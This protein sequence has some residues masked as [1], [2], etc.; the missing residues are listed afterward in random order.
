MKER[1]IYKEKIHSSDKRLSRHIHHDSKS[2]EFTF[3]TSGLQIIDIEHKRLIPVLDQGQVGSCTG[4]AG[5]GAINTTP[6]APP[7]NPVFSA[8]ENGALKLYSAA[9]SMDGDGPY[10]PNDNGSSG[11]SIAKVLTKAGVISGYQHTFTLNDALK[12]LS[13]YPVIVGINWYNDMFNPD[14]DGRVHITGS[15]A[16]GHEVEA[17]KVDV[18][19][20][21]IWF[22][23]SWG[24][25]WGVNGTFYITWADFHTLLGEQGDVTVLIP[26]TVTPPTPVPPA[27]TN[28]VV[29]T[30]ETDNGIETLGSIVATR[31]DGQKLTEFTLE[32]PW[33]NNA[34]NIS[35]IPKGTY[36]CSIKPFHSTTQ[37]EVL[38]VP[39]RS[40]IYLHTGNY[41]HDSMGCI[42]LG[43]GQ[44]DI[45]H[46]G[47]T[48]VTNST[49]AVSALKA[50]FSS[51]DF[52]L[53]IQ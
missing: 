18:E 48:D 17:Y 20:G 30:R 9:E 33:K 53:T 16:G 13:V 32:L 1:I 11:L 10:P 39:G 41:F 8:N 42:I 12:A 51:E 25:S 4:N 49:K 43:Q 7:V 31:T 37:Y 50:F 38:N 3:N 45:N 22:Y 35:C 2:K 36:H 40:G 24:T 44:G 27:T 29:L 47:Q 6:F 28:N 19:N 21:R 52:T 14:A 15:L 5:I 26:P 46:D 23:N 34:I